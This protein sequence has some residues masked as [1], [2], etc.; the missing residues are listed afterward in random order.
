MLARKLGIPMSL[1]AL[2]AALSVAYASQQWRTR[3]VSSAIYSTKSSTLCDACSRIL[4]LV[5]SC[6]LLLSALHALYPAMKVH[7][8][9]DLVAEVLLTFAPL[10]LLLAGTLSNDPR[11]MSN[12][13][14]NRNSNIGSIMGSSRGSSRGN[15]RQELIADQLLL[16]MGMLFFT[17]GVHCKDHHTFRSARC[18][19][20]GAVAVAVS[21]LMRAQIRVRPGTGSMGMTA[22]GGMQ[23][24]RIRLRLVGRGSDRSTTDALSA[25]CFLASA[26]WAYSIL[27]LQP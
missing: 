5:G 12:R 16:G 19:L 13:N 20:V 21:A 26:V 4:E 15:E 25:L 14:G 10:L 6:L 9:M 7:K 2:G 11:Y 3:V 1:D 23:S 24:S 17:L 8:H 27:L 18:T 22:K